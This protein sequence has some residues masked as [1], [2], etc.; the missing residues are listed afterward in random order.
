[1]TKHKQLLKYLENVI[2]TIEWDIKRIKHMIHQFQKNE[3]IEEWWSPE[4]TTSTEDLKMIEWLFDGYYMCG[5]DGKNYPVPT[6]YASKSKLIPWDNLRLKILHDGTLVYKINNLTDRKTY[7]AIL[8]YG[9]QKKIVAITE[10]WYTF[11]LNQAAVNYFKGIVWD[12]AYIIAPKESQ[13]WYA[14]L[15]TIVKQ[16]QLPKSVP[17]ISSLDTNTPPKTTATNSTIADVWLKETWWEYI[18]T[19]TTQSLFI[20]PSH[21]EAQSNTDLSPIVPPVWSTEDTSINTA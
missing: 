20:Q 19:T 11:S 3:E 21:L 18:P 6:N 5:S 8:A 10:E 7:K 16:H 4:P 13:N 12:D 9:D 1:M 14:A 17:T 2:T 15:E